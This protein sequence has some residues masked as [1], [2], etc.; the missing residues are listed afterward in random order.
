MRAA[1]VVATNNLV[2]CSPLSGPIERKKS[3]REK[4]LDIFHERT[5]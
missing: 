4:K 3:G 5:A 1:R 2:H